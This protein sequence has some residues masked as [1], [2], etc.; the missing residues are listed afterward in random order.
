[1]HHSLPQSLTCK[2]CSLS[3]SPKHSFQCINR[4]LGGR[5][6]SRFSLHWFPLSSCEIFFTMNTP[7]V[8]Y[9]AASILTDIWRK[10]YK[11]SMPIALDAISLV[12]LIV[13]I[14][15][16]MSNEVKISLKS[17]LWS[18]SE[19][20]KGMWTS[21]LLMNGGSFLLNTILSLHYCEPGNGSH[22][23]E[24]YRELCKFSG[25]GI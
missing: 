12:S 14:P 25:E 13:R 8:L 11:I 23:H 7:P 9:T 18:S 1:L 10:H 19:S 17:W 21:L 4:R 22:I 15:G 20:L 2:L 24:V 3:L 16:Y 6:R 5:N